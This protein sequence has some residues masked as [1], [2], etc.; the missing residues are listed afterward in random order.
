MQ[1]LKA[2]TVKRLATET[3]KQR[4]VRLKRM[5]DVQKERLQYET[6]DERSFRLKRLSE[7]QKYYLETEDFLQRMDRLINYHNYR[8]KKRTGQGPLRLPDT[9]DEVEDDDVPGPSSP[10]QPHKRLCT[11]ERK[12]IDKFDSNVVNFT[13]TI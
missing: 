1:R 11:N 2:N 6:E 3:K 9:D 4:S 13:N 8:H 7:N 5:S 12:S 10:Q